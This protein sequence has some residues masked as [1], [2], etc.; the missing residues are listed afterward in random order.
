MADASP[1]PLTGRI[2]DMRS[3]DAVM[4]RAQYNA[5]IMESVIHYAIMQGCIGLRDALNVLRVH[6]KS[7]IYTHGHR[8]ANFESCRALH[9]S[10]AFATDYQ[11]RDDSPD[12]QPQMQTQHM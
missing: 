8:V 2:S 6:V 9:I 4:C 5:W 7:F 12:G 1:F 3:H 11:V 10:V